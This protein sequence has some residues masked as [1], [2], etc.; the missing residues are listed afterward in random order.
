MER[1]SVVSPGNMLNM[2][3][4]LAWLLDWFRENK[5]A[6]IDPQKDFAALN[7]FEAG[8]IDSFGVIEMIGDIENHFGIRFAETHFQDRRFV[9]VGGL[10][11]IILELKSPA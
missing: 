7:Y 2:E 9:T 3:P 10:S 8:W 4:T 5:S 11:R 6:A 1:P